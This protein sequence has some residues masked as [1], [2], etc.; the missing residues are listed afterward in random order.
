MCYQNHTPSIFFEMAL[1][2][3]NLDITAHVDFG[4]FLH[5]QKRYDESL[6]RLHMALQLE[7]KALNARAHISFVHFKLG[8]FEK[9]CEWG[10]RAEEN[11]GEL[12]PGYLDDMCNR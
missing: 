10:K 12:E 8:E 5:T 4:R 6:E 2:K 3:P 9:A 1:K 7:P 11:G